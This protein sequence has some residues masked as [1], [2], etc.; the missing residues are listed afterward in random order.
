MP[1]TNPRTQVNELSD[2]IPILMFPLRIETRFKQVDTATGD[3]QYQLWVR[4]FPDECSIDTFDDILSEAEIS[5]ARRYWLD[6]WKAGVP[7]NDAIKPYIDNK[8]RGAWRD[9][10][11]LFKAG[12]A[13]WVEQNY[14]PKNPDD[15]PARAQDSD[16]IVVIPAETL[17]ENAHQKALKTYWS[18]YL[19]ANGNEEQ[20]DAAFTSLITTLGGDDAGDDAITELAL[21]LVDTYKPD[22]LD[23]IVIDPK[24]APDIQV[25]F[26]Q[27]PK[28]EDFDSKLAAW[29][30]AA[31][32][33]TLPERLVL[34][35]FHDNDA[36]PVIEK[37]GHIIPDPL[38]V[39]PDPGEDINETLR[40]VFGAKFEN[41]SDDVKAGKYIE[42]LSTQSQTRW[43]FDFDEAVSKGM[44]FK[45]DIDAETYRRGFS[46]LF[47]LGVKLSADK[48]EA[49]ELLEKLFKNHHQGESGFAILP[50]GAA[51]NNT[52]NNPS[53][54]ASSE[55]PDEAYSRY[56][57][58]SAIDDPDEKDK[59][60]DGR[61][62]VDL[63]GIETNRTQPW[64]WRL[65]MIAQTNAKHAL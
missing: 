23:K 14:Q 16:L 6:V 3:G 35:G 38:I 22:N 41:F 32:V 30:Q 50:Q 52:E 39:G 55:D 51:T 20:I 29:S 62:L 26:L 47:V 46:R 9:L 15:I 7:A 33:T 59:K 34:L 44:G 42:Y 40:L 43:M 5:K 64:R 1:F 57:A 25:A 63:L 17:P 13:Y 28:T 61:W 56:H 10:M 19:L 48:T 60:L 53:A 27:F 36:E 2:N 54:Y 4:V 11:G 65:V 8:R 58:E 45:V 18:A 21:A 12:R 37:L 49:K 24:N 31:K